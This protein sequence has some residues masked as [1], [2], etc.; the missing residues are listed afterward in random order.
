MNFEFLLSIAFTVS[1]ILL[2]AQTIYFFLVEETNIY[3]KFTYDLKEFN[4]ISV[5]SGVAFLF[6]V[7]L[8]LYAIDIPNKI[9]E[10][11]LSRILLAL[12]VGTFSD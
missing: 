5:K 12:F 4:F 8:T 3:K 2:V 6:G 9:E 10:I 11:T 7:T 1:A